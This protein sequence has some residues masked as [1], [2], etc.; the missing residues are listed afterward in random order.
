MVVKPHQIPR[1]DHVWVDRGR[2]IPAARIHNS[3]A[4]CK[5]PNP[6]HRNRNSEVRATAIISHA[7]GI[8]AQSQIARSGGRRPERRGGGGATTTP[9][10][11]SSVAGV[12][13]RA[14]R[15][16]FWECAAAAAGSGRAVGTELGSRRGVCSSSSKWWEKKKRLSHACVAARMDHLFR[17]PC[18]SEKTQTREEEMMRGEHGAC[19]ITSRPRIQLNNFQLHQFLKLNLEV[20]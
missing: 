19:A 17:L 4:V 18:G 20:V 13:A 16:G 14:E 11:R 6:P 2:E 15:R 10:E 1:E 3:T 7:T 8:P 9:A 12:R 5:N